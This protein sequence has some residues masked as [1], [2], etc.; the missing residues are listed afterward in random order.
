MKS[1]D[2]HPGLQHRIVAVVDARN[3][4][5][6]AKCNLFDLGKEVGGNPVEFHRADTLDGHNLLGHDLKRVV[7]ISKSRPAWISKVKT[8]LGTIQQVLGETRVSDSSRKLK[9]RKKTTNEIELVLVG[10]GDDLNA[11]IPA[12]VTASFDGIIKIAAVV[13]GILAHQLESLVPD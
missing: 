9:R 3:D 11:E 13:V 6:R 8:N 2:T 12:G 4:M 5:A 7:D 10:F 1:H